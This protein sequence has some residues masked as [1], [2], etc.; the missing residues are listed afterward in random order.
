MTGLPFSCN[1]KL[2]FALLIFPI[3]GRR[4]TTCRAALATAA[5]S[6]VRCLRAT[7]ACAALRGA[8]QGVRMCRWI[9]PCRPA[10]GHEIPVSLLRK[11]AERLG[12]TGQ[13]FT[14]AECGFAERVCA[15]TAA[16]RLPVCGPVFPTS[17]R[18]FR[19]AGLSPLGGFVEASL[20][21]ASFAEGNAAVEPCCCPSHSP[22]EAALSALLALAAEAALVVLVRRWSASEAMGRG[23]SPGYIRAEARPMGR[24]PSGRRRPETAHTEERSERAAPLPGGVGIMSR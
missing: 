8:V 16:D 14:L 7:R 11:D 23:G 12:A 1:L 15:T 22:N 9:D 24:L 6:S 10:P 5:L 4:G 3:D 2:G 20:A 13:H 18:R 21:E 17:C 19:R